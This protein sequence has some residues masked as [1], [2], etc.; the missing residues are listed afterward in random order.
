MVYKIGNTKDFEALP[1]MDD[2]IKAILYRYARVL[3]VEYGEE[4]DTD[5]DD[6][7]YLLWVVPHTPFEDVKAYFD[8]S[9]HTAECVERHGDICSAM[10]L[11]NNDYVITVLARIEDTPVEILKEFS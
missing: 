5:S 1:P 9:K 8:Y 11:L 4:R 10:Y 6:G 3:S 7:G 2:N